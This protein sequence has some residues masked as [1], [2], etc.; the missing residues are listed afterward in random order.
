MITK[1]IVKGEITILKPAL[2]CSNDYLTTVNCFFTAGWFFAWLLTKAAATLHAWYPNFCFWQHVRTTGKQTKCIIQYNWL[3]L[4]RTHRQSHQA[5]DDELKNLFRSG[6]K[7]H[8][9]EN[10]SGGD[11]QKRK[12]RTSVRTMLYY[13][14]N[15][16]LIQERK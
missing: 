16:K 9:G 13:F 5:P 15:E 10:L 1:S 4:S 7:K 12:W 6:R 14:D 8:S 2:R 11:K 3:H